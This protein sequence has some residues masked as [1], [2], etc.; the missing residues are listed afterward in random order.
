VLLPFYSIQRSDTRRSVTAP[1]PIGYSHTVDEA[2]QY[3]EWAAPWP[4]IV[5]ARG[6]GKTVNRVFP[7]FSR[8]RSELIEQNS[9]LWPVYKYR[10]VTSAP[11]DRER[12]RIL[13][14]L[15]SDVNET[16][17]ES[18]ASRHRNDLWPFYAYRHDSEGNRRLQILAPLEPILPGNKSIER[19]WS[20]LWS[21]WRQEWNGVTGASSQSLLWNLYRRESS[22]ASKKCSLL[23]GLIKYQ[24]GPEGRQLRLFHWPAGAS[25]HASSAEA[26]SP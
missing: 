9:Y 19:N 26:G 5:F 2:G 25:N 21:L 23:F 8:A 10:R 1:W 3:E 24:S 20:P 12:T 4:L 15:Y 13:F 11:L 22:G 7:L 16:N 14:F 17:T 18:G 6:R